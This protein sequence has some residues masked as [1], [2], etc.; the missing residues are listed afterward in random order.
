MIITGKDLLNKVLIDPALELDCDEF[1]VVSS[2]ATAAMASQHIDLLAEK[3]KSVKI[4]VLVGMASKEGIV[5]VHHEGFKRLMGSYKDYFKC[6]YFMHTRTPCHAKVYIWMKG[7]KPVKSFLGSANY[8]HNAFYNFQHEVL[9]ECDPDAALKFFESFSSDTVYCDLD[10]I[11]DYVTVMNRKQ[12][13][14]R[15]ANIEEAIGTPEDCTGL[16][17]RTLSLLTREGNPGNAGARLNWGQRPGREKNQAYLHIP[18]SVSKEGFFPPGKQQ[19]TVLTDDGKAMICVVAQQNDK[20]IE[21]TNNNSE[22]GLYF[23]KRLGLEPGAFVTAEDLK[24]YGRTDVTFCKMDNETYYMDF[25]VR[26]NE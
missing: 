10:E 11:E 18:S 24:R 4:R 3:K 19:F 8:T 23:R 15:N 12:Y 6:S 26:K 16:E 13:R 1:R 21:T 14:N 17:H 9:Y 25:S 20:G 5:D 2:Y 7:G 22:L